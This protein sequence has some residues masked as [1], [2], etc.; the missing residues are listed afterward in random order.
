MTL[1]DHAVR[2]SSA[3]NLS[4]DVIQ[5]ALDHPCIQG[6]VRGH[7]RWNVAR[8]VLNGVWRF[9]MVIWREVESDQ[10][11][12]TAYPVQGR[13]TIGGKFSIGLWN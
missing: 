3:R 2:K 10:L 1:T 8:A 4:P 12:I 5:G 9:V 11:V 6:Y 7:Y 13:K